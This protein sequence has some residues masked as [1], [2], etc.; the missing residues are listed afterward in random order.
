MSDDTFHLKGDEPPGSPDGK[1][2]LS[3]TDRA[4]VKRT[5]DT[6]KELL[7]LLRSDGPLKDRGTRHFTEVAT[8]NLLAKFA[9][10]ED[11]I[12][13]IWLGK[14]KAKPKPKR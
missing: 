2:D 12:K 9:L 14:T 10:L 7:Y 6:L 3:A 8:K 4:I 11:D 5:A 13:G 1:V